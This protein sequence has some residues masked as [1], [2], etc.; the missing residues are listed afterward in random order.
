[1][2]LGFQGLRTLVRWL[3]LRAAHA[4]GRV[5][6]V[7]AYLALKGQRQLAAS[8]LAYAFTDSISPS[9]RRHIARGVFANLGRNAVEWLRLPSISNRELQ[10]LITSEGIEHLRQALSKGNG[11]VVITAHFGNWELI[12][13]YLK[14]LGFEG[15]V[16]ARRL[17]YPE[18]ESFLIDLRGSRGIPTFARGSLREVAKLLRSN[19]IVGMLPDQDMD[20]LEGV[21]VNFFNHPTYTPVGPA[22]LSLMTNAPIVPCF[23][24]RDGAG[25]RLIV[26][27]PLSAPQGLDRAQAIE[28]LTQSWSGIV[29]S[30]I[31]RYPD[32]WVWM[33]RRWKTQPSLKDAQGSG[34]GAEGCCPEP[35]AQSPEPT[36]SSVAGLQPVISCLLFTTYCLLLSG[37]VGCA[38]GATP[39]AGSSSASEQTITNPAADPD[40]DATQ[41]MSN[42]QLTGYEVDGR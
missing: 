40:S 35:R 38:K 42:F 14:S 10:R 13:L 2:Y 18:Y 28:Q 17:R 34:L 23:I 32:H 21:F 33:H 27:P 11:A 7:F 41:R 15:G 36:L 30:Y 8:H 5:L 24:V 19:Q 39:K 37:L 20:S 12:P 29:E 26:E 3:P 25:F 4:L 22:A 31:R 9:L 6:G 1:M 16:L